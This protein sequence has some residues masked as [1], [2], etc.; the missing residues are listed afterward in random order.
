MQEK[1]K[2]VF[3]QQPKASEP[4]TVPERKW[5]L[6]KERAAHISFS[7]TYCT[8]E[9]VFYICEKIGEKYHVVISSISAERTVL[10]GGTSTDSSFRLS[11]E[12]KVV[13]SR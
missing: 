10:E 11:D 2:D 8:T 13:L 5:K 6:A 7:A 9:Y 3:V 12:Q 4:G 1:M